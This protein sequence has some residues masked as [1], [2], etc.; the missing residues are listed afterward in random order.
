MWPQTRRTAHAPRR[1]AGH[2][3][4]APR[5]RTVRDPDAQP[6]ADLV[7]R[8]F[9][10]DR[11]DAL[12]VTDVTQHRTGQGRLY[13]AVVLDVYARR[14]LRWSIADHPRTELVTMP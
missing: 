8:R 6:S 2:L 11:P 12:W 1:A 9:V 14:V 3:P 5:G 7:Q 10:A 13:C 4:A